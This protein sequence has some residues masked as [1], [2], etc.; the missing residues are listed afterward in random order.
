M[1]FGSHI[2]NGEELTQFVGEAEILISATEVNPIE[3]DAEGNILST[4]ITDSLVVLD[5]IEPTF[6]IG[7][8]HNTIAP[9]FM[10]FYFFHSEILNVTPDV[11][12]AGDGIETTLSVGTNENLESAP[13]VSN[14]STDYSGTLTLQVSAEDTSE[15]FSDT[16]YTFI[17]QPIQPTSAQR[18]SLG[19]SGAFMEIP[20]DAF[21]EDDY[22]I[23]IPDHYGF[24][25]IHQ[26]V[27]DEQEENLS[28]V[29]N[30]STWENQYQQSVTF[31]F[32]SEFVLD[33][34]DFSPGFYRLTDGDW[35][36]IPTFVLQSEN[37][38]WCLIDKPGTYVLKQGAERSPVIL[39]E[40]FS[41]KQNYPN[42]FNPQTIIE[43][44]IPYNS[45]G[46]EQVHTSLV[47]YDILGK[48]VI[49][50]VDNNLS[51]GKYSIVWTGVNNMGSRVASG[52]YFYS[53]RTGKFSDSRRMI[54]LR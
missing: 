39:P 16:T 3:P 7:V 28:S 53:L 11:S 49:K 2:L 22:L 43:Y 41:L 25:Y 52:I 26:E 19:R 38:I 35:E 48:E 20:E 18:I 5:R 34:I 4:S 13:Y 36:Y 6:E 32:Q 31:G 46:L 54:L 42:P 27:Y 10:Q 21:S 9:G 47:I 45:T 37:K 29:F 17:I 1:T 51:P 14:L 23:A 24:Q 8:L 50:L 33:W 40:E 15:N 44:D 12:I 30:I